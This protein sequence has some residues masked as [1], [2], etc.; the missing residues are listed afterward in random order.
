[1]FSVKGK[2]AR[3]RATL[4]LPFIFFFY[5]SPLPRSKRISHPVDNL[6]PNGE[7]A[8]ARVSSKH[9]VIYNEGTLEKSS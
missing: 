8:D 1:M 9:G 3:E 5:L 6:E 4:S 2:M 7:K